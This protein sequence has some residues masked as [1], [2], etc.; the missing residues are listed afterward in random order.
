M[1]TPETN[2]EVKI[3]QEETCVEVVTKEDNEVAEL[4]Q[5]NFTGFKESEI[6]INGGGP[7]KLL[8]LQYI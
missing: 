7:H 8:L 1:T 4:V 2:G 6:L 3:V 5:A